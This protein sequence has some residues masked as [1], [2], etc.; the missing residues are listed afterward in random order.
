MTKN[1]KGF[2][3]TEVLVLATVII[4]VLIFMYSQF[5]NITRSYEYSF[6]YDTVEGLYLANNIVNYINQGSYDTLV[7]NLSD[8]KYLDIYNENEGC[9]MNYFQTPNYCDMLFGESKI[10][11]AYFTKENLKELK[12]NMQE[13]NEDF[14]DFINSINT[15]NAFNDYRIIIK[16]KNGTFATMRFNKGQTYIQNGL[17]VHLDAINNTGQGHSNDTNIWKDLSGNNNDATLYNNPTWNSNALVLNGETNYAKIENT[18]NL[19]ISNKT[20]WEATIN[21]VS[22]NG[23]KENNNIEI[24]SNKETNKG[25]SISYSK[26]EYFYNS[27]YIGNNIEEIKP[28]TKQNM[29]ITYT[30]TSVYDNN[31]IKLYINGELIEEKT[32]TSPTNSTLPITLGTNPS[33]EETNSYANI[34]YQNIRIYNRAL[35]SD[36]ILKNYQVDTTRY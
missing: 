12:V 15:T 34:K 13:L 26:D 14:K 35:T 7:S 28:P 8:K 31:K 11:Q 9:N 2:V 16:Y 10:E 30:I 24:L 5:K 18:K 17:I 20:T 36:E 29:N 3:I 4:G 23:I 22:L 21:I 27:F 6:K 25:K 32:V 19:D 1:N 33:L